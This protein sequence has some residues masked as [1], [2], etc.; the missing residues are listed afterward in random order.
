MLE[1]VLVWGIVL[2][3]VIILVPA[4]VAIVHRLR[5]TRV[6]P[7]QAKPAPRGPEPR[8]KPQPAGFREPPT[9][10]VSK[11]ELQQASAPQATEMVQWFGMLVA[12][13]GALA[14]QRFVITETGHAIGRDQSEST[15][16]VNDSRIS[17]RHVRIV[18]RHGKV[19]AIDNGSTNG[20]FLTRPGGERLTERELKRGDVLVL[21]D[22]AASFVY[23]T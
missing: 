10:V 13:S 20:T 19:F 9:E 11:E 5:R 16:V 15:I 23:H 1:R 14:G 6:A 22:N 12:T 2:L 18:V 3:M 4:G 21:A 17:K 8:P 7:P